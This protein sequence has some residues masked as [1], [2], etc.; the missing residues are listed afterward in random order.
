MSTRISLKDTLGI[1]RGLMIHDAMAEGMMGHE[2]GARTHRHNT[3]L[4]STG[5]FAQ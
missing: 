4:S 3:R 1:R 2:M 5:S